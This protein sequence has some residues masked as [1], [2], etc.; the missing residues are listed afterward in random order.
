MH[1]TILTVGTQGDVQP[2]V[3]LGLGLKEKGYSVC[4]ATH[5]IFGDLIRKRGV[6]FVPVKGNPKEILLSRAGQSMLKSGRQTVRFMRQAVRAF[7][8]VLAQLAED[9]WAACRHTNAIIFTPWTFF[10]YDLAKKLSIPSVATSLQPAMPTRYFP[11]P[12]FPQRLRLGKSYNWLT[13]VVSEYGFWRV[14]QPYLNRWRQEKLGFPAISVW[15]DKERR[16]APII[17][18]YSQSFLPKPPDWGERG[19]VTG[20]WFLDRDTTWRAPPELVKFLEDGPPPVYVGFGSMLGRNAQEITQIVVEALIESKQRGILLTGWGGL[21]RVEVPKTI[22]IA[23]Y[24][25]FDWLFPQVAAVVH[26]GGI[27]T[28]AEGLRAGKPTVICPLAGDQPFWGEVVA[29]LGAG[30]KPISLYRLSKKD[31]ARAIQIAVENE[32]MRDC[33]VK[34]GKGITQEKGVEKAVMIIDEYLSAQ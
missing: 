14:V 33:A 3:A 17:H 29:G 6:E 34:I 19:H 21:T 13:H 9:C 1:I 18:G 30:P 8:P 20:F 11:S 31:L 4:L 26:H 22:Y 24:V 2:F 25:P 7:E 5:S 32:R 28:L 12:A 23:E 16:M 15:R 10:G 27:G